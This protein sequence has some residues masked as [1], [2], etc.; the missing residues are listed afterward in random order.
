[1]HLKKGQQERIKTNMAPKRKKGRAGPEGK[2]RALNLLCS[3]V[4]HL[5]QRAAQKI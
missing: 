1:L 5:Q 4:K 2:K 3:R